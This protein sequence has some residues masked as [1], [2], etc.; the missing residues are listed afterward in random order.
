[1]IDSETINRLKMMRLSGMAQCLAELGDINHAQGLST[2]DIVKLAVDREWDRRQNS[3]L[4]RLA[5]S[6]GLAQ[7]HASVNDIRHIEGRTLD[8]DT[9][10]RLAVGN[11]L[12]QR[13]DVI[14]QG[15]AGVG[16]TY[17]ACALANKAIG[18]H[19][20]ALY[21]PALE[22]FDQ[23]TI[24]DRAGTRPQLFNRLLKV[25]LLVLDDWFLHAPTKEQV[26][27]LH[28]LVDRRLG[29]GSTIYCTQ[30]GPDQWHDR[31]EEKIVA[32]AIIDRITTNAITTTINAQDSLRKTFSPGE[33]SNP[34]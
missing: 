13:R 30:L 33:S 16:K 31:M 18:Q 3:K 19:K 22:L 9:I 7:P 4:K 23:I 32:D 5:K 14:L 28:T 17:L 27:H 2:P 24:A 1:M 11:Y 25:H 10:A 21:L 20:T 15:P 26:Q 8:L 34:T 12:V 29:H 6:A